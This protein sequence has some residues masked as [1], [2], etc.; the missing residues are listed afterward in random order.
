MN[1]Q[2]LEESSTDSD[3][4]FYLTKFWFQTLNK[5]VFSD[6]T[7]VNLISNGLTLA[8]V[9]TKVPFR[10]LK[11][12]T[13]KSLTNYYSPEFLPEQFNN[14]EKERD[15]SHFYRDSKKLSHFDLIDLTP[16]S[17]QNADAVAL[18]LDKLDF[19]SEKYQVTRNW[20]HPDISSVDEFWQL[21]PNR[22]KNTLK[23]RK[24][25]I[26]KENKYSIK[27]LAEDNSD[28]IEQLLSD[29]HDV[30][31]KSWKNNEPYIDFIDDIAIE[32]HKKGKLR[33]GVLYYNDAAVAAQIWFVH[34][35]TAYIFKLSYDDAYRTE[36]FGSILMEA[37]F[38]HVIIEDKVTMVDFL[39][40]DDKYKADW[41]TTSRPLFGIKAYNKKTLKG[42]ICTISIK[43]KNYLQ[44]KTQPELPAN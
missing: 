22:L 24:A 29:Y 44:A 25:K 8:H 4:P 18:E 36:S 17:E 1:I 32:E 12:N 13:L 30:Y 35:K 40:G 3:S 21:R 11:L 5:Y 9:K 15:I 43:L 7:R 16:L 33:L 6:C 26:E 27:I 34:H 38:N 37:L 39:T 23:R 14:N 19:Y 42:F 10:F 28:C 31:N 2:T 41:M 20:L